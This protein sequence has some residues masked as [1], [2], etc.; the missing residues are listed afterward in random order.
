MDDTTQD[1]LNSDWNLAKSLEQFEI[2]AEISRA[3]E[4]SQRNKRTIK[5]VT[6]GQ[7]RL[8]FVGFVLLVVGVVALV[9][10]TIGQGSRHLGAG[11]LWLATVIVCGGL[12]AICYCMHLRGEFG[13]ES[14]TVEE[15]TEAASS[16]GASPAVSL[17]AASPVAAR[18]EAINNKYSELLRLAQ[19]SQSAD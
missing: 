17:G 19:A 14:D 8:F 7:L 9:L 5:V 12:A 15:L 2:G 16:P 4:M 18:P 11:G 3:A 6:P 1:Q 13:R 10:E